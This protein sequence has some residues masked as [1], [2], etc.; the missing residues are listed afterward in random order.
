MKLQSPFFLTSLLYFFWVEATVFY[1]PYILFL[2]EYKDIEICLRGIN[3]E[4]ERE[5]WDV[6][7]NLSVF[8]LINFMFYQSFFMKVLI[9]E[10]ENFLSFIYCFDFITKRFFCFYFSFKKRLNLKLFNDS[11]YN[12]LLNL[13]SFLYYLFFIFRYI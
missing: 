10:S 2:P 5:L 6:R 3:D 12:S 4:C 9:L 11:C 7:D 1:I 8:E 13:S